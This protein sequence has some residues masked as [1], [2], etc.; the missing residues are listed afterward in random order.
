MDCE[1]VRIELSPLSRAEL[2]SEQRSEV[3]RHLASCPACR[4]EFSE[5]QSLLALVG[6][7]GVSPPSRD[8]R[9][10]VLG[11]VEEANLSSLLNLAVETPPTRI[12]EEVM[13]AARGESPKSVP[14]LVRRR[15]QLASALAAAALLLAGFVLGS[16]ITAGDEGGK[17]D[18]AVPEGHETQILELEGMGPPGASVR[19]YRHDNFRVT[20]SVEGYEPTPSGFH[21]AVWV[22]GS[23]GDAAVGTFRLKRADDFEIPFAVGVNPSVYSRFVVTLEPNDGDPALTGEIVSEGRFDPVR[24]QHGNYDD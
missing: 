19:H 14:F 24:V 4:S 2:G 12:K 21:Y 22:R 9:A 15:R 8:L 13:A 6:S 18:L 16:A 7:V 10:S 5:L 11:A 3:Q 23:A 1:A 20:L 17:T